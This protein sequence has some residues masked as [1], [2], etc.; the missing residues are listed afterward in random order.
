MK[1]LL[2]KLKACKPALDW[3]GDKTIEQ[4]WNECQRGD[5]LL[6][7]AAKLDIDRKILVYAASQCARTSLQY[8]PIDEKR[9]LIAIETAERW[10]RGEATLE[11]VKIAARD[12]RAVDAVNAVYAVYAA[13]YAAAAAYDAASASGA[14]A[15]ADSLKE[16]AEIV[17]KNIPYSVIMSKLT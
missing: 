3:V 1:T 10:T 17:R 4:A 8:V 2:T 5:W 12:N 6:W 9:P 15:N 16:S 11:E 14:A 13:Y 7:L